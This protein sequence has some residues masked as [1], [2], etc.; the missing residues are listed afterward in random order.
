MHHIVQSR[1]G[2]LFLFSLLFQLLNFA[3]STPITASPPNITTPIP[4]EYSEPHCYT[5]PSL[6]SAVSSA[7]CA[8]SL[9]FFTDPENHP[10][11]QRFYHGTA[12]GGRSKH[13]YPPPYGIRPEDRC[14]ITLW[15]DDPHVMTHFDYLDIWRR[16]LEIVLWCSDGGEGQQRWRRKGGMGGYARLLLKREGVPGS[17]LDTKFWVGVKG[18]KLVG[19]GPRREVAGK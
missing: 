15:S 17:P 18:R 4:S 6:R 10:H 8:P 5:M 11:E 16:A 7:N 13:Y 9:S 12:L 1:F 2:P 19:A 14:I 3:L